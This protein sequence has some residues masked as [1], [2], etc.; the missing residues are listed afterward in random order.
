[1]RL[2]ICIAFAILS[3]GCSLV[4]FLPSS[5]CEYVEY[6]RVGDQVEV[7]ASCRV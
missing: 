2:T 4:Q 5:S 1:M 6:I 7:K 3:T